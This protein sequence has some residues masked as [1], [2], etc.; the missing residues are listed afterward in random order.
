MRS[1]V[2]TAIILCVSAVIGSGAVGK[3]NPTLP[4]PLLRSVTYHVPTVFRCSEVTATGIGTR[5]DQQLAMIE[6]SGWTMGFVT[7]LN[8]FDRD[9]DGHLGE[10]KSWPF[11]QRWIID[12]CV[13]NSKGT[14]VDALLDYRTLTA[15]QDKIK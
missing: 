3:E 5:T 11:F 1:I 7:A 10:E 8:I 12:Y 9:T 4:A 13:T 14:V 15:R 6:L 2:S